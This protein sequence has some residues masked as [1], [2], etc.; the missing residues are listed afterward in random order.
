MVLLPHLITTVAACLFLLGAR[1]TTKRS[2]WGPMCLIVVV[3]AATCLWFSGRHLSPPRSHSVDAVESEGTTTVDSGTDLKIPTPLAGEL[4]ARTFRQDPL[5][6]GIQWLA[7][8]F[9]AL[10]ALMALTE[11]RESQ[12]AAEH[13]GLLLFVLTGMMLL[14]VAN[15]LIV[16]FMAFEMVGMGACL[17]V[18]LSEPRWFRAMVVRGDAPLPAATN[19][20]LINMFASAVLLFGFSILYGSTGTTI[21]NSFPGASSSSL[22]ASDANG[23]S[24]PQLSLVA[25][26]FI[27]AAIGVKCGVV[28]FHFGLS[29]L[30]ESTPWILGFVTVTLQTSGFVVLIRVLSH[31]MLGWGAWGQI[32][33]LIFA[34]G[35]MT[36]GNVMAVRAS[37]IRAILSY[38]AVSQAGLLLAALAVGFNVPTRLTAEHGMSDGVQTALFCLVAYGLCFIGLSAIL[39]YLSRSDRQMDFVEDLSGL[40]YTEPLPTVLAVLLLLSLAGLPPLPG[41]WGR[42]FIITGSVNV[43]IQP[44]PDGFVLPDLRFAFLVLVTGLNVVLTGAVMLRLTVV[45]ALDNQRSRP[46]PVG[47][48]SPLFAAT[49]AAVV[50]VILGLLPGSLMTFIDKI[51]KPMQSFRQAEDG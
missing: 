48:Q 49:I 43:L 12:T 40:I 5:S 35:G 19:F 37:R 44:S 47:G 41:F 23:I 15:D 25:L 34:V 1:F 42:L 27:F 21:L 32:V 16:L 24:S 51:E 28:G 4:R 14:A 22:N 36:F 7:L 18:F 13:F 50:L 46:E 8:L 11:Q 17:L 6:V 45:V 2:C 39:V 3:L 29:D 9:N 33:F 26:L 38:L 10:F 20:L 30:A 31:N